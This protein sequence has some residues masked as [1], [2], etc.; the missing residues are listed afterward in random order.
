[1][2]A[3]QTRWPEDVRFL[4]PGVNDTWNLFQKFSKGRTVTGKDWKEARQALHD[5]YH[6][7]LAEGG[8]PESMQE[9][10]QRFEGS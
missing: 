1:M 9:D 2:H 3:L 7:F 10:A 8:S 4:I 5:K 6:N